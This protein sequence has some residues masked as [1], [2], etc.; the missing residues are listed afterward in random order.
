MLLKLEYQLSV[1][2]RD[3][4]GTHYVQQSDWTTYSQ[5]NK[6]NEIQME[7]R[8]QHTKYPKSAA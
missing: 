1:A 6:T 7:Q 8:V 2:K 3:T 5:S 4:L